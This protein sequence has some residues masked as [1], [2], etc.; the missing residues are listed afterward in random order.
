MNLKTDPLT[1]ERYDADIWYR[2]G[3]LWHNRIAEEKL[4]KKQEDDF[5]DKVSRRNASRKAKGKRGRSVS[6][7]R[8]SARRYYEFL[9]EDGVRTFGEFLKGGAK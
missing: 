3:G 5:R 4:A 9:R 7:F 8:R 2:Q 1:G 6:S